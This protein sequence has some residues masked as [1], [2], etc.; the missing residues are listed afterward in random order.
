MD[1]EMGPGDE[2]TIAPNTKYQFKLSDQKKGGN[3]NGKIEITFDINDEIEKYMDNLL[4][5][6][7]VSE[8]TDYE[9]I[10]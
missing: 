7:E 2:V 6:T 5:M 8:K 10:F 1:I 9:F 3:R 4:F